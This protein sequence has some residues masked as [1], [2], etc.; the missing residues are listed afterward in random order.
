MLLQISF[1]G[2]L[3]GAGV[4]TFSGIW[5]AA[6]GC[7]GGGIVNAGLGVWQSYE[8]N[9]ANNIAEEQMKQE[10]TIADDQMR[11]ERNLAKQQ[12]DHEIIMALAGTH[13]TG[14]TTTKGHSSRRKS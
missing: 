4:G 3:G 13:T 6:L 11:Q 8:S 2:C 7:I 9:E 14:T 5:G 10:K 12:E 1:N